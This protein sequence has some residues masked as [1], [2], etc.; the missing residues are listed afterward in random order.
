MQVT[1]N[2]PLLQILSGLFQPAIARM[3]TVTAQ[4]Q[5]VQAVTQT[6]AGNRPAE[7]DIGGKKPLNMNAPRGTY[8]DILV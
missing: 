8:L 2:T 3:Q 6:E 7:G 5:T 1:P 4:P